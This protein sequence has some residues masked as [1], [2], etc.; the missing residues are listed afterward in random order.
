MIRSDAISGLLLAALG[1]YAAVKAHGFGL[2]RLS[3][4]GAGFFPFWDGVLIAGCASAIVVHAFLR[5]RLAAPA[6]DPLA[7]P[8]PA[9]NW[10]KVWICVALLAA[11]AAALQLIGFGAS[12]FLVMLALSRMDPH[13]TWRGAF[14]I[15]GLGSLAF[16]VVFVKLL[17][18][19]F[20][21]PA[22]GF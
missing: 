15:A 7:E 1:L 8:A 4:P 13:T 9:T 6:L 5:T 22:I 20:P 12:T 21:A 10:A 17:T 11:Y 3:E 16:W 19:R 2:G 14:L 18:V